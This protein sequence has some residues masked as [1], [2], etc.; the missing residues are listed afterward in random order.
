MEKIKLKGGSLSGTYLCK[1]HGKK[2]FI[3]KEA[4][5]IEHREYGYQRWYSQ[6]KRL[7]RY[8]FYFPGVFPELITYGKKGDLAYFDIE[9]FEDSVT[10]HEFLTTTSDKVNIDALFKELVVVMN[11]MHGKEIPST[12]SPFEL[13]IYEEI[14]Q[15][16]NACRNN[17]RFMEFI[18]LYEIYFNGE[19]VPA[20]NWVIDDFKKLSKKVYTSTTETFT[21]GNLTLENILYQ[22]KTGKVIFIDPYEE[23][24]IDSALCDYSQIL[25]SCN[26][27]YEIYNSIKPII[28]SDGV[29]FKAANFEGLN[30]FNNKFVDFLKERHSANDIITIRLFEVS[31]YARM[32]PFKM[33]IDEDKML[34]FYCLG[35][36]LFHQLTK[37]IKGLA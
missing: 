27:K 16:I 35:S 6:L 34:F 29:E 24:I 19:K 12:A 21:H 26:S 20:L 9:F 33:E 32:L 25:Q 31:Q 13:Y 4:S 15:K 30:Y 17:K 8:N 37:E 11:K 14:E 18:K 1:S 36:Y 3:R 5:L 23:N 22:P 7:Q 10:V 28:H 2:P